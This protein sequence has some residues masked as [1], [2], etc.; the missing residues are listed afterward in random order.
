VPSNR[1]DVSQK[2]SEL[3]ADRISML[4]NK[5][6]LMGLGYNTNM[7]YSNKKG[8]KKR[9]VLK[10]L[11]SVLNDDDFNKLKDDVMNPKKFIV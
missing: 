3:D 5:Y 11:C 1:L 8:V 2:I 10:R 6:A 7:A 4:Y 9:D